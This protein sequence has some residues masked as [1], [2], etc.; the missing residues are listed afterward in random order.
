MILK[1]VFNGSR[2]GYS[3]QADSE[4]PPRPGNVVC[5]ESDSCHIQNLMLIW[6]K[7]FMKLYLFKYHFLAKNIKKYS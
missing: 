7:M 5:G 6:C 2:S 3:R 1:Q 4:R